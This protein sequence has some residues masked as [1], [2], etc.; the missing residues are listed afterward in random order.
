MNLP[1]REALLNIEWLTRTRAAEGFQSLLE[2]ARRGAETYGGPVT[3]V[4]E[5]LQDLTWACPRPFLDSADLRHALAH[6]LA[7]GSWSS[8]PSGR[9]TLWSCFQWY[10]P[11]LAAAKR[12][13]LPARHVPCVPP[14]LPDL[15]GLRL[16]APL[17]RAW[18]A[19]H[20]S[21]WGCDV[22]PDGRYV[23]AASRG[24]HV[25]VWELESDALIASGRDGEEEVRDCAVTPDSRRVISV[26]S[27]GKVTIWNLPTMTVHGTVQAP[28]SAPAAAYIL[29]RELQSPAPPALEGS[30]RR[31]RRF[32]IA[33]DGSRLAVAGWEAVHVWELEA[34]ELVT[35]LRFDHGLTPGVL[36][37]S[38]ASRDRL[39]TLAR[40]SPIP[41]V[42][43]D[44]SSRQAIVRTTLEV[45]PVPGIQRALVTRDHRFFIAAGETATIV[46]RLDNASLVVV[47]PHG[48]SGQALAV[49]P[50]GTLAATCGGPDEVD[51]QRLAGVK[52]EVLRLWSLPELR[53]LQSWNL[54]DFG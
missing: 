18:L 6:A 17:D 36:A 49:S 20:H 44:L 27:S 25:A 7:T 47:V 37:I 15:A 11:A 4:A 30:P 46:W 23:L 10:W 38:F 51:G 3:A 24:G 16:V 29:W 33:P 9:H 2:Y 13:E 39:V 26:T 12:A 14:S 43:W 34:L 48:V 50:D 42:T 1:T 54:R 8:S 41:A 22:S 28:S 40:R 32:A 35:T 31:W 45:P 19:P 5:A 53:P 52:V 21:V